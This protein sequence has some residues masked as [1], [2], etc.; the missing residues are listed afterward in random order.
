L[1][2]IKAQHL[3]LGYDWYSEK[4]IHIGLEL[5]YQNL[6][7]VPVSAVQDSSY[8]M[9]NDRDGYLQ[10]LA[11]G[12]GRGYNYGLDLTVEKFF[13]RQFFFLFAS[14]VY[15]SE[16]VGLNGRR[17]PTRYAGMFSNSLLLGKEF[18]FKKAGVLQ[19]GGRLMYAGSLRYTPSDSAASLAAGMLVRDYTRPFE[20]QLRPYFR[21]D[22]RIAYRKSF[23]R[24]YFTVAFDG[25]NLTSYTNFNPN[26]EVFNPRTQEIYFLRQSSLVP[27]LSM[28]LDF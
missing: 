7:N 9:L 5:Y 19:L 22:A 24:S 28:Q 26:R 6:W 2:F 20:G 17:N 4:G 15:Q 16:Y 3:V 11:L 8:W 27:V 1:P 18:M 12:Q 10:Q 23:R 25:Q 13:A 14:S 21:F